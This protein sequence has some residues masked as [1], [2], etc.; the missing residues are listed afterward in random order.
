M[1]EFLGLYNNRRSEIEKFIEV[2]KFLE[3]KEM[4]LTD[5][6]NLFDQFFHA[7]DGIMLSYQDLINIMKSNL[8]LMIYNLIEFS[9]TNLI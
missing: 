4:T 7:E 2:M 3:N 8:S 1:T 5:E 6:G 9:V